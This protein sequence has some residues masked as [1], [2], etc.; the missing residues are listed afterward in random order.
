M[1][2]TPTEPQ[3]LMPNPAQLRDPMEITT[4]QMLVKIGVR[5][6]ESDNMQRNLGEVL[7]ENEELRQRAET[8]Q[9]ENNGLRARINEFEEQLAE[10][11]RI[12]DN[13]TPVVKKSSAAS[14]RKRTS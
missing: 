11:Q 9:H 12:S 5:D 8:L 10:Q 4:T 3:I 1:S 2:D 6:L 7:R 14:N 13:S